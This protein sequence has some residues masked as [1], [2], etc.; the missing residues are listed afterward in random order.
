M[1]CRYRRLQRLQQHR[2]PV[3][4]WTSTTPTSTQHC[5]LDRMLTPSHKLVP[6]IQL[7]LVAIKPCR[8]QAQFAG[9]LMLNVHVHQRPAGRGGEE[10]SG[11]CRLLS[12]GPLSPTGWHGSCSQ[13]RGCEQTAATALGSSV[14][15]AA[16]LLSA[17]FKGSSS[18]CIRV[19]SHPA[20]HAH[21]P[22]PQPV[23]AL[24]LAQ[25]PI[26][27]RPNAGVG[28]TALQPVLLL[29]QRRD[30]RVVLAL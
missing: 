17:I 8:Q 18:T 3:G 6:S 1:G 19:P 26:D 13:T 21:S 28:G 11:R 27:Q 14:Y 24:Q 20:T 25:L 22:Q 15:S 16:L 4:V 7:V 5:T 30:K 9:V 2:A 29:P 23:C 12:V 10:G